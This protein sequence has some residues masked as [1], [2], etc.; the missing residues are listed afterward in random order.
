MGVRR[1]LGRV[2]PGRDVRVRPDDVFLVSYP[3]SGNTWMRFLLHRLASPNSTPSFRRLQDFAPDIYKV[4]RRRIDS[5]ASPRVLKSHEPFDPR[6]GRVIYIVRDPRSVALSYYQYQRRT[7][8]LSHG[9]SLESFVKGFVLGE[10]DGFGSWREH[11]Q[12]WMATREATGTL[13][14]IRY[15][16]LLAA[17]AQNAARV[18]EFL[19][20]DVDELDVS[21]AVEEASLANMKKVESK[22]ASRDIGDDSDLTFIGRG[23]ASG[24]KSQLSP[25]DANAIA[26]AFADAMERVGYSGTRTA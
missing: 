10:P 13:L 4:E 2:P 1:F 21:R 8:A 22:E 24:W 3:R 14:L 17:P 15:E 11:V 25:E 18:A 5:L 9:A 16:D 20:L 26:E 23:P 6:Y 7:G 12:S 19:D